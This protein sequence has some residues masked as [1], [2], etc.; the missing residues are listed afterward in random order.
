MTDLILL[1][2]GAPGFS[3]YSAIILLDYGAPGFPQ[4]SAILG[5]LYVFFVNHI[6]KIIPYSSYI[7]VENPFLH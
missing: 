3:Q 5:V 6:A 7:I 2:Y 1:D 4:Y